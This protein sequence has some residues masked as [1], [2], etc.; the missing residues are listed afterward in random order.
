MF[1]IIDIETTGGHSSYNGI[2]EIAIVLHNG[3]EMEGNYQTLINPQIPIQRYVQSLTGI[4]DAMVANA[5]TFDKVAPHI[6]NLLKDRIFIAHNVNFDYAFVKQHLKQAGIEFNQ[7]K[8]CTIRLSRKIFPGLPKYGL[9]SLCRELN[10]PNNQRHRAAGDAIATTQLF[11][12]LLKHDQSGELKKMMKR[13]SAEQYLPPNVHSEKIQQ[14]PYVPGVYYFHDKKGKII[15]VG[16]A[17]NLKRRV[18]SHFSNNKIS[19][20]KQEFL[21]QIYDITWKELSSDFIASLFESIEIKR[22]WPIFNK[23]QKHF[24]QR[25]ALYMYED[26]KGYYRLGIDKKRKLSQPLSSFRF[27]VEAHRALWKLVKEHQLHPALCFLEKDHSGKISVPDKDEHNQNVQKALTAL[28]EEMKT[29][30]L[31]DGANGYVFFEE[32]KFYGLGILSAP[33]EKNA[34][35]IKSSLTPY[36]EN[37]ILLSLVRTY[38]EKYPQYIISL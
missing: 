27:F 8:L 14:L 12:L 34:E 33:P 5:P 31:H 30:L 2:T 22:L 18:T 36:P 19:K 11:E 29:Y 20:Q 38:S 25:Y 28:K 21:R 1:A 17:K 35:A 23:S 7:P 9:E 32:G 10:I 13:G 6:Y 26:A 24:E 16:K 3:R 37:E 15:Y 4:T